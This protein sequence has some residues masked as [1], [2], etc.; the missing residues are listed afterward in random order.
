MSTAAPGTCTEDTSEE[1]FVAKWHGAR[2]E[3]TVC[4]LVELPNLR[5]IVM[6]VLI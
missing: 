4:A 3:Y 1:Y 6:V 2:D 5:V